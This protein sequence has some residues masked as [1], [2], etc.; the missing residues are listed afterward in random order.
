MQ[1]PLSEEIEDCRVAG[2]YGGGGAFVLKR[3]STR[4]KVVASWGGGWDHVSV[5]LNTRCPTWDEMCW[6][7]RKFFADDETV[8]QYHPAESDYINCHPFC[9]HMWRP[10]LA[11]IPLP[12]KI[13]V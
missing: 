5:S 1:L 9:L 2:C 3:G 8:I 6:V 10:Q 11:E 7:K 12:P 4:I 13:F